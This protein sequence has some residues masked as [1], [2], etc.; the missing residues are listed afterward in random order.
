MKLF[1]TG[2]LVLVCSIGT[3]AQRIGLPAIYTGEKLQSSKQ[4]MPLPPLQLSRTVT[5]SSTLTPLTGRYLSEHCMFHD[6]F[7][8]VTFTAQRKDD[9]SVALAFETANE[10]TSKNFI[11]ERVLAKG[12]EH[13]E[14]TQAAD[15][16]FM[17]L[18]KMG[19]VTDFDEINKK[20]ARN[21]GP[22]KAKYEL[23]D[24]NNYT[25]ISFYRITQID[26]AK[27]MVSTNIIAVMGKPLQETLHLF[28]N[29]A[30]S[31]TSIT[32]F[33]K[34]ADDGIWQLLTAQGTLLKESPMPIGA[35]TNALT[36][37]VSNLSAGTYYIR[38]VRKHSPAMQTAF[39]KM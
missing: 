38:V 3:I 30:A 15:T 31:Q 22:K 18:Y 37:P 11:V 17:L 23:T 2:V 4:A 13:K 35:G 32:L 19:V 29:P 12:T 10:Y 39:I 9:Q 14:P 25:G 16:S 26:N 7:N 33:S 27:N 28:P 1:F 6:P 8:F 21:L 20:Y 5:L 34:T 36:I 24:N